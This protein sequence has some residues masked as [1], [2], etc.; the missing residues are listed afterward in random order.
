M[1]VRYANYTREKSKFGGYC[2]CII[3]HS[4]PGVGANIDPNSAIFR[5]NLPAGY[6]KCDGS[7]K[8]AKEFFALSK[9]L[10]VGDDCRFKKETTLLRNANPATGDLGQFQLPDLGSKVIVASGAS[11]TYVNDKVETQSTTTA[12]VNRV[13]PQ[14]EVTSNVGTRIES[15]FIGNL[16]VGARNSIPFVGN[17][18]F[19]MNTTLSSTVL[20]IENFQS[21]AHKS[22]QT[23]LNETFNHAVG[24]TG[25]K[26]GG[27][28]SGNSG[29]GHVLDTST[30]SA[31]IESI[32]DHKI[33]RPTSYNTNF[34]YAYPSF[35]ADLGN[36]ISYV[37]VDIKEQNKLDQLVT[38]FILVEYLIKY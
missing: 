23:W 21:H 15:Q 36:I 16:I 13:G 35:T 9:I 10:G 26:D 38:P 25:G 17:S 1:A 29:A 27:N 32:H 4:T 22:N 11:G 7:V 34:T 8:S 18:K 31:S 33:S 12:V 5:E 6:L 20:S 14:I 19:N 3:V 28:F 37:D 30:E 24:S 2:G